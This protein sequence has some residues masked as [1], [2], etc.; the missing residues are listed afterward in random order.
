MTHSLWRNGEC[1]GRAELTRSALHPSR[2]SGLFTPAP[3]LRDSPRPVVQTRM[4]HLPGA[5]QYQHPLPTVDEWHREPPS[6]L[7]LT[8]DRGGEM[9]AVSPMDLLEIRDDE[10]E[11]LLTDDIML[12]QLPLTP[13][14]EWTL[15]VDLTRQEG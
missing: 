10:G 5:P 11:V 6:R 7:S 1:L 9:R 8:I 4:V 12:I 14:A 3:D 13:A 2:L 15:F